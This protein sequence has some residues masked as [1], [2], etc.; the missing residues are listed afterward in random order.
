MSKKA[1][2]KYLL[3]GEL[4]CV[5]LMSCFFAYRILTFSNSEPMGYL[6]AR[7][8]C[9]VFALL[10]FLQNIKSKVTIWS[11]TFFGSILCADSDI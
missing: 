4:V 2:Q 6:L 3:Y 8:I 7:L 1:I 5:L 10:I 11:P 9:F